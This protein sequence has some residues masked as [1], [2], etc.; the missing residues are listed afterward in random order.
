MSLDHRRFLRTAATGIRSDF[1][2]F[3]VMVKHGIYII[4][5]S[6]E[7]GIMDNGNNSMAVQC[8]DR[9]TIIKQVINTQTF[10]S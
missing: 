5:I 4:A 1:H 10:H 7:V 2:L 8:L 9:D 3:R 6:D